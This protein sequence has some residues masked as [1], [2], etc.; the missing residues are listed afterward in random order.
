MSHIGITSARS[1]CAI[2]GANQRTRMT[3]APQGDSFQSFR[4]PPSGLLP[5][6]IQ[7]SGDRQFWRNASTAT[8]A[9][10]GW[11]TLPQRYMYSTGGPYMGGIV[12]WSTF[13]N[14][15]CYFGARNGSGVYT[16]GRTA[17]GAVI[18]T[19]FALDTDAGDTTLWMV[20]SDGSTVSQTNTGLTPTA[21][22]W[23]FLEWYRL[24]STV[25][26]T[27]ANCADISGSSFLSSATGT[28]TGSMPSAQ[29]LGWQMTAT[30]TTGSPSINVDMAILDVGQY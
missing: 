30:P 18:W 3:Y 9:T 26:W 2:L 10:P 19:G 8:G 25:H 21:A 7:T 13:S 12:S 23:L 22:G 11:T 17:F 14:V 20:T 16:A 5:S 4:G 28:H 1:G 24:G 29:T 15:R 6:S 27:A